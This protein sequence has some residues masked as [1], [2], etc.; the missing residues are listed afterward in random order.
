MKIRSVKFNAFMNTVLTAS[1]MLTS[2]IL[3]PYVTRVLS[4]EGYGNVSFAQSIS[5]WLSAFC[6]LGIGTYG[7]RECA[8]VRDNPVLLAKTVKELLLLLAMS[9]TIVLVLFAISILFVPRLVALAPLMW[10]F[11]GSTLLLSFGVEWFFQAIEQYSYITIRSVIFKIASLLLVLLLVRGKQD[12]LIYG[13]I[14]ALVVSGNNILNIIRMTH[15]IDLRGVK[16]ADL[17]KHI[18]PLA[19]FSIMSVATAL[20]LSFDSTLLGMLSSGNFQ[21]GLYQL[22]IKI[23]GVAFQVLNAILSVFIPRLSY[24]LS[25]NRE[26]E[27]NKLLSKGLNITLNI[28]FALMGY[29]LVFSV[30]VILLVSG[31]NYIG[32]IASLRLVGIINLFSGISFL[33]G[34]CILTPKGR[35]KQLA[36][37]NCIGVPVSILLNILLDGNLGAYGASISMLFSELVIFLIQGWYSRVEIMKVARPSNFLKI[38]ASNVAAVGVSVI[39]LQLVSNLSV[40]IQVLGSLLCYPAMIVFCLLLLRESMAISALR[41]I[42]IGLGKMIGS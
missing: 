31:E 27:Y 20:Y 1:N 6:L 8:K 16:S 38:I 21:V 37:A 28:C 36:I 26:D 18:K 12:W 40:S 39:Y 34:L 29:L 23:K 17:K 2:L 24:D 5:Q 3:I 4:V 42:K 41:A 22:A 7:I 19:S 15:L 25:H 9:T 32:A 14:I 10:I 11:L 33:F 35:E 13:A 30:P